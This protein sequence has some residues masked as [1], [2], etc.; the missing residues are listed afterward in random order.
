MSCTFVG[1]RRRH[2]PAR[3]VAV[4]RS[5]RLDSASVLHGQVGSA[6]T[7]PR[8]QYVARP[9][10]QSGGRSVTG[11]VPDGSPDPLSSLS[12]LLYAV[13]MT[14]SGRN[15][16]NSPTFAPATCHLPH[17]TPSIN[18]PGQ[19]RY[20]SRLISLDLGLALQVSSLDP[21]LPGFQTLSASTKQLQPI[22]YSMC[23]M[24]VTPSSFTLY[25]PRVSG[26]WSVQ[27]RNT[28]K[29]TQLGEEVK[30]QIISAPSDISD[31]PSR[32]HAVYSLG[33]YRI[34]TAFSDRKRGSSF[35]FGQAGSPG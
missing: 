33:V 29:I 32:C 23:L 8:Y 13:D 17:S 9:L 30:R 27:I 7:T 1:R 15:C 4:P 5:E 34:D 12:T 14:L 35:G 26:S 3:I 10:Q 20:D 25:L 22:S 18:H 28:L 31:K 16:S 21:N 2:R 24:H 11:G 6:E 19:A